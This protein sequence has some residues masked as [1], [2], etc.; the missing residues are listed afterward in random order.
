MNFYITFCNLHHLDL[1]PSP[2]TLSFFISYMACQTGPSGKTISIQTISSYLSG[3]AHHLEPF[4]PSIWSIRKHPLVIK[5]LQGA[6]KTDGHSVLQKLPIEDDHLHLLVSKLG[7]SD[8]FDDHL[9]LAICFTA[10]HGLMRLREIVTPDNPKKLNFRKL[11][12]CCT[13]EFIHNN[14]IHAFKFNLP[15][16]KVDWQYHG[17]LVV[18]QSRQIP[19]DPVSIFSHYLDVRDGSFS[20]LLHLWVWHDGSFP[21]HSWFTCKLHLFLPKDFSGHSFHA[22]GTTHLTAAGISND[23]IQAMGW[24][25]SEAWHTYIH[26]NPVILLANITPSSVFDFSV[27]HA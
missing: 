1:K 2:D 16:H 4:Y 7:S 8:N 10:Y 14:S 3:I 24:W 22:G 5:T 26:K 9:F 27:S 6:E 12:L 23:T 15:T 25:S 21:S 18:I 19:L 17:N 20:F 11:S 13:V